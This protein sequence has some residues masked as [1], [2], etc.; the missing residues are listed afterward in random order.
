[1]ETSIDVAPTSA[2]IITPVDLVNIFAPGG[3]GAAAINALFAPGGTGTTAINGAIIA[4]NATL[5]APGGSGTAAINGAI[6]PVLAT[7]G[8]Q[9]KM[10][11]NASAVIAFRNGPLQLLRLLNHCLK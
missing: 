10:L 9:R 7:L 8:N 3:L 11:S 2:N 4:S 1:M 6:A 5:F